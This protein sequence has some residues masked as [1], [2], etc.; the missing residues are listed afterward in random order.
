RGGVCAT[1][2]GG[3]SGYV[4]AVTVGVDD[5]VRD[6]GLPNVCR[7][8]DTVGRT[9]RRW[10]SQAEAR[11]GGQRQLDRGIAEGPTHRLGLRALDVASQ[12][13]RGLRLGRGVRD[14][15]AIKVPLDLPGWRRA[16][17]RFQLGP[18]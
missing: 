18:D 10:P 15:R 5:D 13:R 4:L 3:G 16:E 11:I 12:D 9:G 6:L 17:R 8:V 2:G 1:R 7:T 14:V